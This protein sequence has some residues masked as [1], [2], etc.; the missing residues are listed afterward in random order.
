MFYCNF[1][2]KFILRLELR[3]VATIKTKKQTLV[4]QNFIHNEIKNMKKGKKAI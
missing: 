3:S 2:Q 4:R 1:N